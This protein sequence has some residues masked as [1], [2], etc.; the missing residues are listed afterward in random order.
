[1]RAMHADTIRT[2][3]QINA[4]FYATVAAD[5]DE[6]RGT[7]WP[8]W[9][10]LLPYCAA[11]KSVLDAG[12][13]N[14][15]FGLF[16]AESLDRPIRYHGVDFSESLLDVARSA[17]EA[18]PRLTVRLTARD[19]IE[20]GMVPGLYDLVGAFGLMHHIPGREYRRMFIRQL[21]GLV[22]PGGVLTVAFWRFLDSDRLR[23]RVQ[24]WPQEL[25][26]QVEQNDYLLDWRRGTQ[27]VRYCHYHT[28]AEIDHLVT[29]SDLRE[30]TRYRA[31]GQDGSLNT[32]VV[33]TRD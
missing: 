25:A 15:R 11:V 22:A 6:T 13:G 28:D 2:L 10:S 30:C 9:K 1:M 7:P 26:A 5:F 31:D 27:A 33:L 14:G 3:N 12:C 29:A 32:Y 17:L 21:A 19:M 20:H 18:E 23:K 24:P 16:L 8:G 4:E